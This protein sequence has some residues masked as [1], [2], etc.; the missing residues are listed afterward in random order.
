VIGR[1]LRLPVVQ[2]LILLIAGMLAQR[3]MPLSLGLRSSRI[4]M[5]VGGAI[6][7][8]AIAV[9]AAAIVRFRRHQTTVEPGQ[10]PSALVTDG[11]F[12]R[13]RN[14]IYVALVLIAA[15]IGI[16]SDSPW[17]LLTA[18]VL[19][20]ILDRVVVRSEEKMIEETFGEDYRAYKRRV[21]RWL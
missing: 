13:S 10:R 18:L 4:A 5:I 15:A 19:W 20:V 11:I 9:A 21:R 8:V 17:I 1:L 3:V 7:V 14:P 6:L 2:L 12:A 16:M